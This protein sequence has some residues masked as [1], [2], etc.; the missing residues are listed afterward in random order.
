MGIDKQWE[1]VDNGLYQN[2]YSG[3]DRQWGIEDN[4]NL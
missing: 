4:G 2:T 3:N 1:L